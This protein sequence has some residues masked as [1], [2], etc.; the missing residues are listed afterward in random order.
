MR[1]L[2]RTTAMLP[3]MAHRFGPDLVCRHC[4]EVTWKQHQADPQPCRAGVVWGTSGPPPKLPAV[5]DALAGLDD[6]PAGSAAL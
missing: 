4:E 6:A 2:H 5:P 1:V 3:S